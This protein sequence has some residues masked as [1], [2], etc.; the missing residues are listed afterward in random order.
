MAKQILFNEKARRV[1]KSGIDK[2]A[3]AVK[4]T[5]GQRGRNVALDKGYGGPTITNDGVSIAKE[6]T[7]KDRFENMGA[8]IVKEVATKTND[9]AGDGTTTSVVLLQAIV[10]EG[11]KSLSSGT[12]AMALKVGIEKATADVVAELKKLAKKIQNDEEIQQIATISSESDDIGKIIA[13]TIKIVGKDGVVTVEESE[14]F[15]IDKEVVEGMQFSKGYLSHYMVTD[16]SRMEAVHKNA[17]ILLTDKKIS[18]VQE[19]LPILEKVAASGKKELVI[20]AD[21]VD[22]EALTTLVVNRL[23]GAFNVLAI[24]APGYGDRKTDTLGDIAALTGGEVISEKTG[25]KFEDATL[26][27]LGKAAKV[28]AQKDSTTIVDGAGTKKAID[29]RV[30][31][32]RAQIKNTTAKFD[33]EELEK[34]LAKMTGGVAVIRV[35]AAT[36]TE[37]KYLKLKIEDAV[38]ATKAA[39]EEGIVAGGGSA[40]LRA[41]VNVRKNIGDKLKEGKDFTFDEFGR[42]YSIVLDSCEKPIK[43]II[44]NCGFGSESII[45]ETIKKIQNENAGLNAVTMTPIDDM[46]KKGIID[47]LKVTRTALERASSA[48]AIFLTTE[49]AIAE[50][51]KEEKDSQGDMSGMEY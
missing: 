16:S 44:E 26:D 39:I 43:Q 50:E 51:P 15:G 46:L 40:L 7:L 38:N 35:G 33:K 42:G 30:S 32:I 4:V 34:R 2:A 29:A 23:R 11:M 5:L 27:M 9:I 3:N 22:G 24:K 1:L 47:P 25:G 36:E 10:E 21:D 31:E 17:L 28:V 18:T 41:A 6:I 20:V 14:S 13:D 37:M 45:L 19:L 8:E 49:V 12:N 48:A